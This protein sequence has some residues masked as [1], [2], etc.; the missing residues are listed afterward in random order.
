MHKNKQK[1]CIKID[2]LMELHDLYIPVNNLDD[3]LLHHSF[4][5]SNT[6]KKKKKKK[7]ISVQG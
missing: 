3:S 4:N 7:K 2:E 5:Q 6:C 1:C